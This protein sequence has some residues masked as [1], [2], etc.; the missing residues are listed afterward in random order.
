MKMLPDSLVYGVVWECLGM[1][2]EERGVGDGVT[3]IAS[4]PYYR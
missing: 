2:G 3:L 4:V 1:G